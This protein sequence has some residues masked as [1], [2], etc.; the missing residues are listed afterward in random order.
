MWLLTCG[1]GYYLV[2]NDIL[3]LFVVSKCDCIPL[4]I[5]RARSTP[6][7]LCDSGDN[8]TAVIAAVIDPRNDKLLNRVF[9]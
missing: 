2:K 1:D 7:T 6:E 3:V 8:Y 4:T 5:F 9:R